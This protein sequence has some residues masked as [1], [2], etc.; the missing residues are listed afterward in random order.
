MKLAL[1][2]PGI[3]RLF[4]ILA[5]LLPVLVAC[6]NN[7]ETAEQLADVPTAEI[8]STP[9]TPDVPEN[10]EPTAAPAPRTA[11][12]TTAARAAAIPTAC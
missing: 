6:G 11:A 5:L 10:A 8:V 3:L 4:G 1:F 2:R 9:E 7:T 12:S